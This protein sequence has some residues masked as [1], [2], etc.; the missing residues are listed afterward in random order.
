MCWLI[1]ASDTLLKANADAIEEIQS[2]IDQKI[3]ILDQNS[4]DLSLQL[5]GIAQWL[6]NIPDI[7]MELCDIKR[8]LQIAETAMSKMVISE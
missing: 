2:Y 3:T 1:I 7:M 4:V 5:G 8:E 6:G